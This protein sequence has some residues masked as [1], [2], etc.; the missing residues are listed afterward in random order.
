MLK[1]EARQDSSRQK[2]GQQGYFFH[3][4]EKNL[5][6]T[7]FSRTVFP[8]FTVVFAAP[9]TNLRTLLFIALP[10]LI[11]DRVSHKRP[12]LTINHPE[13]AMVKIFVVSFVFLGEPPVSM[14]FLRV[15]LIFL[16]ESPKVPILGL[17]F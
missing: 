8:V 15:P 16:W 9:G 12:S 4:G 5:S 13:G 17:F 3:L 14:F 11:S 2:R 6:K 10:I 1:Y 7:L